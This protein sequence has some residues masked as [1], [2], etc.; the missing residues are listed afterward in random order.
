MLNGAELLI[1]LVFV[2]VLLLMSIIDVAFSNVNK[3]SIRRLSDS[4]RNQHIPQLTAWIESR[5]EVLMS[6]Q[7]SIQ[8]LLVGGAVFLFAAFERREIRYLEGIPGTVFLMFLLI[9][10]FRQ[11]LPRLIAARNPE[12]VLLYLFTLF[13]FS[14]FVM[15]PF[16]RMLTS[17][18]NYFHRWEEVIE[19]AK[20]EETSEEEI[21]AFID[22]G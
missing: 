19:P 5:N 1:S 22:A 21:Q 17:I 11:L 16:S 9:L 8:L 3:L 14:Q 12:I 15:R 10:L 6:I 2:I 4:T 20:E 7:T 13:R 18:L